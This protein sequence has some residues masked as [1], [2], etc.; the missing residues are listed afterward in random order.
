LAL[1]KSRACLYALA[2]LLAGVLLAWTLSNPH[3]PLS[4]MVAGTL[5]TTICLL[6]AFV[7][8]ITQRKL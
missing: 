5:A 7:R 3:T 2:T 6:G 1:L 4:Y 8:F